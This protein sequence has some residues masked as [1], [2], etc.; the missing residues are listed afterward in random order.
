MKQKLNQNRDLIAQHH[1]QTHAFGG[2]GKH[3]NKKKKKSNT[4]YVVRLDLL[5]ES[6][7]LHAG[8]RSCLV[9]CLCLVPPFPSSLFSLSLSLDVCMHVYVF[10]CL[11]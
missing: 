11:F 7:N 9:F 1:S 6:V 10:V 3:L 4:T 5:F 2:N 8:L